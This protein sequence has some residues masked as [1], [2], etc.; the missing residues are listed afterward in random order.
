MF[1]QTM[2]VPT[3]NGDGRKSESIPLAKFEEELLLLQALSFR[4]RVALQEKT[5]RLKQYI[6]QQYVLYQEIEDEEKAFQAVELGQ[7][8]W[9][10]VVAKLKV[11]SLSTDMAQLEQ[12]CQD[13]G[14]IVT[15]YSDHNPLWTNQTGF[16]GSSESTT[17]PIL[18]EVLTDFMSELDQLNLK[19]DRSE[20]GVNER[21][22]VA[23][24]MT[25][26]SP[27]MFC[28]LLSVERVWWN[29]STWDQDKI[30]L[31]QSFY[32]LSFSWMLPTS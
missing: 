17:E 5:Q 1:P 21:H 11:H 19:E 30:R 28:H 10:T 13:L 20:N 9:Q 14:A 16:E 27:G 22:G 3:V 4:E 8:L 15:L 26:F 31:D 6:V 25:D 18:T 32:P 29:G 23:L 12:L 2:S 24:M 7:S